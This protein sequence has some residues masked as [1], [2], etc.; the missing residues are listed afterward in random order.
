[1][2]AA[3]TCFAL[4]G[5]GGLGGPVAYALAAAGAR[6]LVV[7]D[8]DRVEL[9]NL[10]RQVQFTT[11]DVGRRKVDALAGE[12]VRRGYPAE[13]VRPLALR[14]TRDNADEVLDGVDV[15]VEGSD[16]PA[17]KFAANDEAMA[18]ALRFA[19]GGVERH[20]GQVLAAVPGRGGCYRCLFEEPPDD[21]PSCADAGV[22]GAAVAVIGGLLARA[23]LELAGGAS[24]GELV[25]VDDVSARSAPRRVRYNPR[26]GCPACGMAGT[27]AQEPT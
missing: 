1:M 17:T 9:S 14:F 24:A 20:G 23:A 4:I 11:G 19:V 8:H 16:H 6:R 25:V 27:A 13:R 21:A 18:R 3:D 12:L 22:L 10:Q 15:L 7:C 26:V 5:A 2:A